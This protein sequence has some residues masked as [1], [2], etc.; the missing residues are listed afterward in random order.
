[1]SWANKM[2]YIAA[3]AEDS[4]PDREFFFEVDSIIGFLFRALIVSARGLSAD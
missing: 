4:E 2:T 1:M 3:A